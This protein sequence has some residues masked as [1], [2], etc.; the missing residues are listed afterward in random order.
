MTEIESPRFI[1]HDEADLTRNSLCSNDAILLFACTTEIRLHC[2][3]H[4]FRGMTFTCVLLM[5]SS[6]TFRESSRSFYLRKA[7]RLTAVT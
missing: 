4:T 5:G 6:H 7:S 2:T 3:A 1:L